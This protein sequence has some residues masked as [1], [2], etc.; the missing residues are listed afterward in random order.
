MAAAG[1]CKCC[2]LLLTNCPLCRMGHLLLR[3]DQGTDICL[4]LIHLH[5]TPSHLLRLPSCHSPQASRLESGPRR[6]CSMACAFLV[7]GKY[8]IMHDCR[9]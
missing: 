7:V 1:I 2:M 4:A 3:Q 9:P 5:C 6:S 8:R